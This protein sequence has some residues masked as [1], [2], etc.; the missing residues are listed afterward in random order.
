M[1]GALAALRMHCWEPQKKSSFH[2][3]EPSSCCLL[4]VDEAVHLVLG[5]Y[6]WQKFQAVAGYVLHKGRAPRKNK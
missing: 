3:M 6:N 1:L 4:G 5:A 2:T